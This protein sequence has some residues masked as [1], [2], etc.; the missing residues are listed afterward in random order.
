VV[1]TIAA[2]MAM[3]VV[4]PAAGGRAASAA[5]GGLGSVPAAPSG[6]TAVRSA[7]DVTLTW[8]DESS[9]ETGFDIER[10]RNVAGTWSEWTASAV[11]A[12][13]TTMIDPAVPEGRYAYLVRSTNDV[14]A[15]DWLVTEL[16]VSDA[17]TAPPAP[18][19]LVA[20]PLGGSV[21]LAWV[22]QADHELGFDI[23]RARNAAGVWTEWIAFAADRNATSFTDS[24]VPD[25]RYAYLVRATNDLGGSPWT[26]V[27]T[28]V[29]TAT[30]TPSA[31]TDLVV[32][33]VGTSVSLQW[34]DTSANETGFDIERARF[35]NGAWTEWAGFPADR[36]ATSAAD[37]VATDGQYAYLIRA[38]NAIGPSAW[39]V[40]ATTVPTTT[41]LPAAP[42][43]LTATRSGA[44]VTLAWTDNS[45]APGAELRFDLERATYIGGTWTNW[46]TFSAAANSTSFVDH[47][48]AAGSHAYLVRAHN[49]LGDSDWAITQIAWI[50]TGQ[51][52]TFGWNAY[53][54]LGDGTTTSRLSPVQIGASTDWVSGAAGYLHTLAV[55]SDETLWAWGDNAYGQLGDGTTTNRSTP[56]QVATGT[57]WVSVT[58]GFTF[59]LGL[60]SDGTL[61]AWGDN[62]YGQL[63]DGTTSSRHL[64]IQVGTAANW[65]SVSAGYEHTLAVRSDGTL[66]AWGHNSYGQLGDGT[67]TTRRSP[68][69][70]GTATDWASVTAGRDHSLAI[71]SDGTLWA[72]GSNS[73]GQLGD[74]TTT[75][76]MSP[77]RVGTATNWVTVGAGYYHSLAVRADGTLW[78]TGDNSSG[79]LGDGTMSGHTVFTKVG[80][81]TNWVRA[82]GA[83]EH[84]MA[85]RA[86]GTLWGWGSGY[87][88]ELGDG[89][90]QRH[91]TPTQVDTGTTWIAVAAGGFHTLAI[92]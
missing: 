92:R 54:Q 60:R 73:Y 36:N 48:V 26:I 34:T 52:T 74:G 39:T 79:Q 28:D 20:T 9:D 30:T 32:S 27:V 10:A 38:R 70:I 8:V 65:V 18:T 77:I 3:V 2:T 49:A 35:V 37:T 12:D 11:T 56:V 58:A 15:S 64:P 89:T 86:D 66:W 4:A 6:L 78:A 91:T 7:P 90:G 63:G 51:L 41:Q 22:D 53:S 17:V 42:T 21:G 88:G 5:S 57:N 71:K 1:A 82:T 69:Q 24:A 43:G 80:T 29:S 87:D 13:T 67:T 25:G 62:A 33:A 81:A 40:V 84:T 68:T 76:R 50:A 45:S 46:T 14:G 31:P 16:T 85:I 59:S 83:W 61:W 19:D 75:N 55:R 44:D 72:W 47:G 23:M